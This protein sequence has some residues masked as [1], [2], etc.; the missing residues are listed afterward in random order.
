M[1]DR[2]NEKTIIKKEFLKEFSAHKERE[3]PVK[4]FGGLMELGRKVMDRLGKEATKKGIFHVIDVLETL[5]YIDHRTQLNE[6]T[7]MID[8]FYEITKEGEEYLREVSN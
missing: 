3:E 1:G 2:M 7:G 6:E 8:W 5:E 4:N